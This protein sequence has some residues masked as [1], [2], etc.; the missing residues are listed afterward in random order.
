[1]KI[2]FCHACGVRI[3][4][5]IH[6][7]VPEKE[8]LCA[9]CN[10]KQQATAPTQPASGVRP[11]QSE[12]V[13]GVTAARRSAKEVS[14]GR[15]DSKSKAGLIASM[16]SGGV[17]LLGLV[18]IFGGKNDA[19]SPARSAKNDNPDSP[20][21]EASRS[22][23]PARVSTPIPPAEAHKIETLAPKPSA[24]DLA[25]EAFER[26]ERFE[27]LAADDL[28]GRQ[29]RI[30]EFLKLHGDTIVA[31]RARRLA[32]ELAEPVA[33]AVVPPQTIPVPNTAEAAESAPPG[34]PSIAPATKHLVVGNDFEGNF[35]GAPEAGQVEAVGPAGANGKVLRLVG[36]ANSIKG[37]LF[38]WQYPRGT[39]Q[40]D[41]KVLFVAPED[42]RLRFRLFTPNAESGKVVC[43]EC[44]TAKT[45]QMEIRIQRN[46]W[47]QVDM[48]L[49]ALKVQ[50][51]ALKSGTKVL[52]LCV[53]LY[54]PKVEGFIDD[55]EVVKGGV[56]AEIRPSPVAYGP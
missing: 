17:L 46:E 21:R 2:V 1:M 56:E 23:P 47:V 37:G 49:S 52:E 44:K 7:D 35:Y 48:P 42:G 28:S 51:Q 3:T 14:R 22:G 27:G 55:L 6:A 20:A 31:A 39:P 29:R 8:T 50:D 11:R 13:A 32:G 9:A 36:K 53:R 38:S 43:E 25:R 19:R 40:R 30:D 12:R 4:E 10:A 24:E 26:L 34:K 18:L 54:G 16:I 33:Q 45:Y 5:P 15:P 41:G